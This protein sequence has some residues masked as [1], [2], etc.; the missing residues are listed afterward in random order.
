MLPETVLFTNPNEE[1]RLKAELP[2]ITEPW[3][4]SFTAEEWQGLGTEGREAF[5][6]RERLAE[7][8]LDMCEC[9][10]R[11]VA[12]GSNERKRS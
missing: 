3:M 7:M 6:Q 9:L 1:K 4:K 12:P 8:I 2:P 11:Q 10:Y 5:L